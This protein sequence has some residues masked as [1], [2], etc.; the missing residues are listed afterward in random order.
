M[1][2]VLYFLICLVATT[3]GAISG[4][5]GGVVIKPVFDAMSGMDVSQI[6]FLSGCTVL[7]LSLIHI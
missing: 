2:F 3:V 4:V 6:S 1:Q 7:A 5:G